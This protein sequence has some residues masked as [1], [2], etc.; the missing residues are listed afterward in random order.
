[1][2]ERI[3]PPLKMGGVP[4]RLMAMVFLTT[5]V[6]AAAAFADLPKV[7]GRRDAMILL[8][9]LLAFWAFE[10]LPKAQPTT[11]A[12]YPQWVT[13]LRVL[14]AGPVIDT[15][16]KTDM[17]RHLYYATGHGHP[18]G[19]GYISRYPRSVEQ[20]RGVFRNLVDAED[21]RTLNRDWGFQYLVIDHHVPRLKALIQD[22]EIR[23]YQLAP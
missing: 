15:T 4:M 14:P 2:L 21:W 10:S 1:V 8:P 19:E 22:G 6:I 17:S 5:A 9:I 23:V 18:V 7:V 20:R 16:Y 13:R 12:T 3:F 11:P